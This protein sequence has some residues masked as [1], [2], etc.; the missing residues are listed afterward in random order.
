MELNNLKENFSALEDELILKK[1]DYD[2]SIVNLNDLNTYIKNTQ[3]SILVKDVDGAKL[4]LDL[5]LDEYKTQKNKLDNASEISWVKKAKENALIFSTIA[6]AIITLFALSELLK[7]KQENI[8][9][10]IK[11]YKVKRKR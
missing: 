11:K 8:V 3:I 7:R 5:A 2:V 1:E 9:T 4:N 6:G 10:K